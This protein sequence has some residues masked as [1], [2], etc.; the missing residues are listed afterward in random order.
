M[1]NLF[2]VGARGFGREVFISALDSKGYGTEFE[3]AGFLDDDEHALD[4]LDGYPPIVDSVE[5]YVPKKNDVFITALG[6]VEAKKKYSNIILKKGGVFISLIHKGRMIPPSSSIGKGCIIMRDV[7]ISTNVK[8][9]DFAS[10]MVQCVIG[11]DAKIGSWSHISPFIFMGGK[12]EIKENVQLYVRSTILPG[13][14]IGKNSIVG[15]GSVVFKNVDEETTV[16]GNPAKVI[17]NRKT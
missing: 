6:D 3:I 9:G 11:H 16:F 5:N 14:T 17:Q 7:G 10:I 4:G 2:I 8:I 15:A 12:S 1:K 13:I